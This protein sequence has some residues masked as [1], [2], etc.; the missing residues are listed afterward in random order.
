M[1]LEAFLQLAH[2]I[3]FAQIEGVDS[4]F[5]ANPMKIFM[6]YV[7][8]VFI[9]VAIYLAI[10]CQDEKERKK[11][12]KILRAFAF[13]HQICP[14]CVIARRYPQ[15]K[16]CKLVQ[17]WGKICPFCVVYRVVKTNDPN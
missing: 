15:G 1:V 4:T 12:L 8:V 17:L 16:F 7:I 3:S 11:V 9:G 5:G 2:N 6:F 13:I 10:E 14:F